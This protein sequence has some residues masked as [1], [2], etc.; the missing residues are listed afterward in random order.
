MSYLVA[1]LIA[2]L[3]G[4]VEG[5]TEWLPISSTGHMILLSAI[6]G[7]NIASYDV[8]NNSQDVFEFFLV[9]I[10]LGAILAVIVRFFSQLNPLSVPK[11][12]QRKD[13][14]RIW[15]RILIGCI[16]AGIAGILMEV[17]LPD[18]AEEALNSPI[19]VGCALLLYGVFFVVLERYLKHKKTKL[20]V[21]KKSLFRYENVERIPLLTCLYIGLIQI[22][23]LIPGT[24]RS[25]VTILSALLFSC[26]RSAAAQYSFYLSIPI[27]IGASLVSGIGF[28][29]KGGTISGLGWT[30]IGSGI[31]ISFLV[32]ILVVSALVKWIKSHTFEGFGYY[33]ILVGA[34]VIGLFVGGII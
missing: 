28:F 25:G 30:F 3:Y 22:L 24:S 4:L 29:V 12:E 18:A 7:L 34:L 33:R 14:G 21:E 10:Q 32:S 11:G 15:L 1:A 27:M 20:G 9:V 23:S 13:V 5:I 31:L 2:A 19:V 17:L 16:P 6:P 8:G 26:T